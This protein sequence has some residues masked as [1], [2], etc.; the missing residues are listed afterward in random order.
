MHLPNPAVKLRFSDK[1]ELTQQGVTVRAP[2][3]SAMTMV[4]S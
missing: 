1:K 2:P 4:Q 3:F